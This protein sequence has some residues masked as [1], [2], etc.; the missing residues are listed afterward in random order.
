M[1]KAYGDALPE[2]IDGPGATQERDARP[3][4]TVTVKLP[5]PVAMLLEEALFTAQVFGLGSNRVECWE[6][7]ASTFLIEHSYAQAYAELRA[8]DPYRVNSLA[9]LKDTGFRCMLCETSKN[10][11]VHHIWP[12]GYHGPERPED[13]NCEAN[14]AP[15][16]LD[17]HNKVQP[18]W[19]SYVSILLKARAKAKN[20]MREFGFRYTLKHSGG[21]GKKWC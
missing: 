7:I 5:E 8:K 9:V 4:R 15:L 21:K 13:I 14:L 2:A 17:C 16:C 18:K 6:A 19:R 10:L 11:T 12:R 1:T 20:Q 3:W